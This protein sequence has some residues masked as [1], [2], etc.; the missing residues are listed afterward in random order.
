MKQKLALFFLALAQLILLGHNLVPHHHHD[1]FAPEKAY[2]KSCSHHHD[3]EKDDSLLQN[4]FALTAHSEKT[5][6]FSHAH[7][8]DQQEKKDFQ[9][10][11]KNCFNQEVQIPFILLEKSMNFSR[12]S[13]FHPSSTSPPSGLRAP[14]F[15]A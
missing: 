15:F 9:L 12:T 4:V 13:Y 5:A 8:T 14:P 6:D 7:L 2:S 11:C 3:H 1:P 10:L